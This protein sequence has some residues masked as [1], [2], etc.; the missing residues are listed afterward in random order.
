MCHMKSDN[1]PPAPFTDEHII[2]ILNRIAIFGGLTAKDLCVI[3]PLLTRRRYAKDDII[4]YEGD[5]PT[6][7]YIIESG[8]VRLVVDF[9]TEPLEIAC[10]NEG[11][12]IGE[13]SVIGIQPHSAT[14]VVTEATN[15]L[16]LKGDVL[17]SL[18]SKDKDLFAR[19]I[20]NIAREACRRLHKS[21][22]VLLHYFHR[23]N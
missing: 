17:F 3:F 14:A 18:Y 19:L 10:F 5:D 12:C 21:D 11:A 16:V 8:E 20:L 9:D 22:E 4:F 6:H 2:N 23:K 1:E 15:L 7:I 13:T